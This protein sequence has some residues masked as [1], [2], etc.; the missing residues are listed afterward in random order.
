MPDDKHRMS[1]PQISVV[2]PAYNA[3][4]FIAETILSVQ[5]QTLGDW[6]HII[7]D[8][9]STDNT[10]EVVRA[11]GDERLVYV[12]QDN[13]GQSA[14]QNAGLAR[15]RGERL[16]MLD[17]DDLL[18]PDAFERLKAGLDAEPDTVLAYGKAWLIDPAGT[19][20]GTRQV[21]RDQPR[22]VPLEKLLER[23][24]IVT[25]GATMIR[26]AVMSEVGG[27]DPDIRMAQDW[28]CW[29][30]LAARGAVV[31]IGGSAVLEYRLHPQSVSRVDAIMPETQTAA[32]E[33]VFGNPEIMARIPRNRAR[34]LRRRRVG[35]AWYLAGVEALRAHDLPKARRLVRGGLWRD[36][37][38]W[39]PWVIFLAT[40]SGRLPRFIGSRIG[41]SDR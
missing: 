9:G 3:S 4:A 11:V 14:A 39:R 34:S 31:F 10:A 38:R 36:P 6:E 37:Y 12:K 18:M 22:E 23:N 41:V 24:L 2:T 29:C 26:T 30:R 20:I 40:L 21:H 28:E 13:A 5:R 7:V 17:A 35:N 8:D 1:R 33:K 19:A 16:V 15:A 25:G 27:F 32:I